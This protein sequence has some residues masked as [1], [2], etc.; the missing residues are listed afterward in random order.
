MAADPPAA[1]AGDAGGSVTLVPVYDCE[2][3]CIGGMDT[4]VPLAF[5]LSLSC[6]GEFLLLALPFPPPLLRDCFACAIVADCGGIV[7]IFSG[8][9]MVQ[10]YSEITKR[11][12]T[13]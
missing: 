10:S 11:K 1:T 6:L 4:I 13:K 3:D 9:P 2:L 12:L 7:S 5:F 8:K